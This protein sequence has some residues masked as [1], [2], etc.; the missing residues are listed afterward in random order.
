MHIPDSGSPPEGGGST[1]GPLG[2]RVPD[3][4]GIHRVLD[5]GGSNA[6]SGGF[7]AYCQ[8]LLFK[9]LPIGVAGVHTV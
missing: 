7:I 8:S 3:K 4:R 6:M 5:A 2:I 1:G 9:C